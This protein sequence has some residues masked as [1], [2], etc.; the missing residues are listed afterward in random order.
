MKKLIVT[1]AVAL[2][3]GALGFVIARDVKTRTIWEEA[4]DEVPHN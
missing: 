1:L 3:A 2:G 4:T